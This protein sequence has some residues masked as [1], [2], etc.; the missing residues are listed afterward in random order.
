MQPSREK[1]IWRDIKKRCYI[2][3]SK[4]YRHYGGKGV[5][6]CPQWRTS[7]EQFLADMGPSPSPRHWLVRKDVEGNYC[8]KNCEWALPIL[9]AA[10]CSRAR[11]VQVDGQMMLLSEAARLPWMPSRTAIK[12]RLA[13]GLPLRNPPPAP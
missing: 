6:M 2:T 5:T 10:R 1:N 7:F 8:P 12:R 11:W 13:K 4:C 3:T 9:Q